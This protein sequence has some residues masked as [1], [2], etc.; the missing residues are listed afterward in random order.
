LVLGA[1]LAILRDERWVTR[2]ETRWEKA[3]A[4]GWGLK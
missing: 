1:G 3:M 4:K 2:R